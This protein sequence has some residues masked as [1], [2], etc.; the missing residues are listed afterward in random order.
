M[1]CHSIWVIHPF[2]STLTKAHTHTAD[3]AGTT[4]DRQGMS[5]QSF[6][7]RHEGG[8]WRVLEFLR[9]RW[10]L[11]KT[12]DFCCIDLKVLSFSFHVQLFHNKWSFDVLYCSFMFM[13]PCACELWESFSGGAPVR[14]HPRLSRYN[15][16]L[17]RRGCDNNPVVD[18]YKSPHPNYHGEKLFYMEGMY[19]SLY[20]FNDIM[21]PYV[22]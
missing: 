18:A 14:S 16:C 8:S 5:L 4:G 1:H 11:L 12:L 7:R 19:D 13:L 17:I 2:V 21:L 9:D 20:C 6:G 3:V 15:W 22:C 10:S